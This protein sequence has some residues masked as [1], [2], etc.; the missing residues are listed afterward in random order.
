MHP[1]ARTSPSLHCSETP[2]LV[3]G[4]ARPWRPCYPAHQG[5]I[6]LQSDPP[7]LDRAE[8]GP[9][10]SPCRCSEIGESSPHQRVAKSLPCR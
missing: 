9:L 4:F 2:V 3:P 7:A 8:S 1:E 6:V 10:P 5:C